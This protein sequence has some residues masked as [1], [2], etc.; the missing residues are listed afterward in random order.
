MAGEQRQMNE[1]HRVVGA[2]GVLGN[3]QRPIDRRVLRFRVHTRC[4]NNQITV[5]A[6]NCL[7]IFRGA[8]FDGLA[9]VLEAFGAPVDEVLIIE[10]FLDD[11]MRHGGEEGYVGARLLGQPERRPVD[12]LDAPRIHDDELS[13]VFFH[14]RLHL[15]RDDRMGLGR[16]GAG[17]EK[18][19][20]VNH[21]G[22]GVAHRRGAERHLQRDHG[23]RM[24][25]SGAV[26]D[27]IAAEQRAEKLL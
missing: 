4:L 13:A 9:E 12:H 24:A 8:W 26:I 2:V 17:D 18:N 16:I 5:D 10:L 21:L 19:V 14:G 20:A 27:V 7:G 6:G 15:Q 1:R 3:P 22:G 23:A 25:Q 11:D